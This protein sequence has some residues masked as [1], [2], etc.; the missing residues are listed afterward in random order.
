VL[1]TR[2][3]PFSTHCPMGLSVAKH[4][5]VPAQVKPKELRETMDRRQ[6]TVVLGLKAPAFDPKD[7]FTLRVMG[8]V[9]NGMGARLFVEL[10]EKNSLAYSVYSSHE[11]LSRSGIFQAYIGCAPQK[12]AAARKGCSRC[13]IRWRDEKVSDEELTVPRPTSLACTKWVCNPTGPR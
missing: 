8:A 13:S 2:L 5:V 11:A 10:R 9:L 1:Q 7:Y 4:I 12:E 6:S 3:E